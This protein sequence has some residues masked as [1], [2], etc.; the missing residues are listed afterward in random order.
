M[1]R[2]VSNLPP[3]FVRSLYNNCMA[4]HPDVLI[5]GGGVIGLTAAHYLA[6]AGVSVAVFDRTDLGQQS[7]WAGAGILPPADPQHAPTPIDQLRALSSSA[8]PLLSRQL[9]ETTGI[10]NGYLICGGI[11]LIESEADLPSDEWHSE[12]T[13]FEELDEDAL[14]QR[15]PGLAVQFKQGFFIPQIGQVRNPWHVKALIA[16]CRKQGVQLHPGCPVRSLCRSGNRII[17]IETDQGRIQAG[18]FL[19]TAGA[20]SEELLQPLGWKPGI[21][22]VRGQIAL[23][24]TGEPGV[25]PLLL[26]GKRYLVPRGDG[27]ILVG[28]TEELAGFDPQPTAAGIAGLLE[29]ATT[30]LPALAQAH[31]EKCWAGLRPG[32]P[33]GLPYLGKVPGVENFLVAAGHFRSGLHLSPGTGLVLRELLLDRPSPVPLDSFRLDR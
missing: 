20:W 16:S 10:E 15:Q 11:E 13:E 2:Q 28:S 24:N 29:M 3:H 19:L 14:R 31:L 4:Q 6:E 22:P 1:W 17:A 9:R 18:R 27:R 21:R 32:S 33:D 25:R 8:Y 30:L 5:I 26:W 7:S 23:L 12:W